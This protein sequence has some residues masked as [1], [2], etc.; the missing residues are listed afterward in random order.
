MEQLENYKV[1]VQFLNKR[2]EAGELKLGCQGEIYHLYI[3]DEWHYSGIWQQDKQDILL[4][5]GV[6]RMN[7][8]INLEQPAMH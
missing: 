2:V 4:N 7:K 6:I 8:K 1:R 3:N 5:N